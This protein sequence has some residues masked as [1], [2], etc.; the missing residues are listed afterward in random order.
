VTADLAIE[1]PLAFPA[2]GGELGAL[3][4]QFD[5]SRT[6]LGPISRWPQSLKTATDIVLRSPLPM[7]MLWGPDGVMIYNDAYAES[8]GQRHPH[9]L[10]SKVLESW[11]EVADFNAKVL[12]VGLAGGTLSFKDQE[13]TLN[14]NNVLEQAWSDLNYGPV[15]DETGRPGGV[16]A[17]VIE[18]TARVRSERRQAFLFEIA[19][20]LRDL[21]SRREIT[22]TVASML[23]EHLGCDRAGWG[24]IDEAGEVA[25]VTMDWTGAGASSGVRRHWMADFGPERVSAL[26]SGR[27]ISSHDVMSDPLI[28]D[29]GA[30]A[31]YEALGIR[32]AMSVPI[33]R[34][35]RFL[36]SVFLQSRAPRRWTTEDETLVR[37]VADRAW[38]AIDR[39]TAEA[40]LRESEARFRALV[41]A[42]ADVV[43]RTSPDWTE[44]RR[45]DGRG[46]VPG[47][48]V[49]MTDWMSEFL[50][51]EDRPHIQAA[52]QDAIRRKSVFQLEH[53][54]RRLDGAADWIASRAV[55][56][57]N[58]RGEIVE[59]FGAASDVTARKHAEAHLNL[60]I[61]E[62][63]HRVK[64][65]LAMMQ[66]IGAQTFRNSDDLVQAQEK[67]SARIIALAKANDLLTDEHW[68]DASLKDLIEAAIRPH[69]EDCSDCSRCLVQGPQVRLSTKT[70]LS[71]TMAFHELATNAVKY[72]A[73]SVEQ[74]RV[75]I[76]WSLDD[77]AGESRL[78]LE[79]RE[80][81]GPV[82]RP[83]TR[84]G[85]GTRLI[86]RGL[87]AELEGEVRLRFEPAGLVC[88]IDAPLR[89]TI[90]E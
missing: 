62:L 35:G 76:S 78:R 88:D 13:F 48:S 4:R 8:A 52:I 32:A 54:I 60:V 24:D 27:T 71:L 70:S 42:T 57:E 51:P 43:Y 31:A 53:R 15:L 55:P 39:V 44:I 47:A 7:V 23:G 28:E 34:D 58:E 90:D 79:W 41:N 77:L 19:E 46:G 6:S 16:V 69:C 64:N 21:H 65:N 74:G 45:L 11:P 59:W 49:L 83:P 86:E 12:E 29:L 3:I 1:A 72:G 82:V 14:R 73:W 9:I 33:V 68:V 25:Y 26:R 36:A 56:L 66:A 75:K 81:G 18:T 63:N 50:F 5:W 40:T 2:G 61:H 30:G 67:F 85:F 22:A 89:G 20:R 87:A 37:E 10:G 80:S 17:V 38:A 84:R